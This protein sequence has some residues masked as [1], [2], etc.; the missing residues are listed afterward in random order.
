MVLFNT[1]FNTLPQV[2]QATNILQ[3][4][5]GRAALLTESNL[6][7]FRSRMGAR[8][9]L[10]PSLVALNAPKLWVMETALKEAYKMQVWAG[11]LHLLATLCWPNQ[12][13]S[14]GLSLLIY[15][16]E[17]IVLAYLTGLF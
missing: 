1:N 13:N 2:V 16:L 17:L 8:G 4:N 5:P 10:G 15:K 12:L 3:V 6:Y 11:A 7:L 14:A 9:F